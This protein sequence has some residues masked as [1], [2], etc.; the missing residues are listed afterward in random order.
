MKNIWIW[1][2]NNPIR[3]MFLVP[4]ILVAIISIS[5]V[6]SWYEL[7]NPFTWA[8]YLS[9][10]IEIGAMTALVAVTNRIKGGVWLMFGLVT[11]IQMVGNIFFSYKE[12]DTASYLFKSWIELT[13]PI[14]EA[15]GSDS[16]DLVAMKRWIAFLEGGLLPIISLTSLHFFVKFDDGKPKI[17]QA[18]NDQITD[19]VTQVIEEDVEPMIHPDA[20]ENGVYETSKIVNE[21]R[22]DEAK[23]VWEKVRELREEGKLPTPTQEDLEDEPTAL[24]F[25]SYEVEEESPIVETFVSS[26]LSAAIYGSGT[27]TSGNEQDWYSLPNKTGLDI[28]K[29]YQLKFR[30]S[31]RTFSNSTAT[32]RGVDVADIVDVQVSRNGGAFISELRITGNSNAT[33]TYASTGVVN[34]TANGSFTNSAAPTGDVYQAPAG[35]TTTAPSTVYLTFPYGTSQLGQL[36]VKV[37]LTSGVF[38]FKYVRNVSESLDNIVSTVLLIT[39]GSLLPSTATTICFRRVV[40]S[41]SDPIILF[42]FLAALESS[43]IFF[44]SP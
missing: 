7:A 27:G 5:H 4:I 31:S 34:H 24:A 28:N 1:I 18:V 40:K 36:N 17:E 3:F 39:A 43:S 42:S 15:L 32:T 29:Q 35:A 23:K 21:H 2:K 26:N 33:W 10:A 25:T 6:V 41:E 12:V 44:S 8:V 22:E 14:W 9:I 37:V 11:F 13:A 30:L 20:I 19:S 38:S 16:T